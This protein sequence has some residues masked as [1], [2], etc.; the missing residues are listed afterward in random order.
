MLCKTTMRA[1]LAHVLGT[2]GVLAALGAAGAEPTG[3]S[4]KTPIATEALTGT[5]NG[6]KASPMGQIVIDEK[7]DSLLEGD[8]YVVLVFGGAELT[9][10]I[11]TKYNE[12]KADTPGE[13]GTSGGDDP[14]KAKAPVD[15]VVGTGTGF[16]IY[17]FTASTGPTP[18][19]SDPSKEIAGT[20]GEITDLTDKVTVTRAWRG[21]ETDTE[22]V[23]KLELR[24][25]LPIDTH[26]R[27]ELGFDGTGAA[28]TGYL[29]IPAGE[30]SYGYELHI[31][32]DIGDARA[33]GRGAP[34]SNYVYKG[35]GKLFSTASA[36][37]TAGAKVE[38]NLLTADVAHD[39]G[40]FS[41]F[42]ADP[43][44]MTTAEAGVLAV[45]NLTPDD[46]TKFLGLDAMPLAAQTLTGADIV[47]SAAAGAFGFGVGAGDGPNG[48]AKIVGDNPATTAVEEDFVLNAGGAPTAFMISSSPAC[49]DGP[50]T[51]KAAGV[52]INPLAE[53]DATFS[54]DA[55]TGEASVTGNGPHYFCVLTAKGDKTNEV[56]I[57]NVGD[58]DDLD[59]YTI[60][61]TTKGG[62]ASGPMVSAVGGSIERDGTT[63][64]LTYLSL[65]PAYSQRLVIVN[66]SS[67]ETDFWIDEFQTE[68]GTMITGDLMGTVPAKSRVVVDVQ[69]QLGRNAGGQDRASGT[70]N[71]TAPTDMIDVMTVQV[72]PGTGQL[73]TTIY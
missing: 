26:I 69:N 64:N 4:L 66:R 68:E 63:I 47:V 20:K 58:P 48:E 33:A 40:A 52:P 51:L 8:Q 35:S 37:V 13:A 65:D 10:Q 67:R 12:R 49:M 19:P 42:K 73:D 1:A 46:Y 31:Y 29:A 36:L 41:G 70:L 43:E 2:V 9:Q 27:L 34:P 54:K 38:A 61:V 53:A 71:L 14:T 62:K 59:G 21:D 55:T 25:D 11:P 28:G 3:A 57:P 39:E 18:N 30:D 5:A 56:A 44:T 23:Y 22:A 50:L 16:R 6:I 24:E 60:Q 32:D 72:H 15:P 45:I 7:I 17:T